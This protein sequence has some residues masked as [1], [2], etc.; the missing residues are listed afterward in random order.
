[1]FLTPLNSEIPREEHPFTISSSHAGKDYVSA[2][3]KI[4]GDFTALVGRLQPGE[5]VL[6]DGPYGKFSFLAQPHPSHF[7]FIAAGVGITPLM[8]M[9]RSLREAGEKTPCLLI[10]GSRTDRDIIFKLELEKMESTM[11]LRVI[12]VL[13][14]PSREWKG[15]KGRVGPDILRRHALRFRTA[16]FYVCGPPA[17]MGA[18][19]RSLIALGVAADQIYYENFSL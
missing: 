13:S 12:H 2:T 7:V 4:S 8:S 3:I 5:P 11:D 17:M 14:Q 19:I 18:V 16:A 10:Y 9:L 15:E 1:M 6:V